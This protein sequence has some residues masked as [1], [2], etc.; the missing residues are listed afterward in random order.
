LTKNQL[1]FN[2]LAV[3]GV[4]FSANDGMD[5]FKRLVMENRISDKWLDFWRCLCVCHDA[6]QMKLTQDSTQDIKSS[7]QGASQDEVTFL[8]M[9][10]ETG[11]ASFKHRSSDTV[12][13][14]VNGNEEVYKILRVIE[15]TSDRKKMS[16]IAKREHDGRVFN[17]IKGA[18]MAMIPRL[19]ESSKQASTETIK[20][21][22]EFASQGLRTLMFGIKELEQRANYNNENIKEVKE[23]ELETDI[24]LL[25]ITGLEDLLQD[26]VA[27]CIT[28]FR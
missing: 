9:S 22:D 15:F 27:S 23:E 19:T 13:I 12:F 6:I 18:D 8:E 1:I 14:Q 5:E 25:G 11:F 4:T 17:F 28:D 3:D 21:M 16:V 26:N 2:C 10:K 24:E 7:Y 20:L